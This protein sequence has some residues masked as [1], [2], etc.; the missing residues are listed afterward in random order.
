MSKYKH[1]KATPSTAETC[2][3]SP[4]MQV[5]VKYPPTEQAYMQYGSVNCKKNNNKKK[6]KHIHTK[7][8]S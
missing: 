3:T 4:S 6:T 8:M 1:V 5:K 7:D 2:K